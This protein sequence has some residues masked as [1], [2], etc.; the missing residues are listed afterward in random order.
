MGSGLAAIVLALLAALLT[1]I[2]MVAEQRSAAA[3]H[4]GKELV[5][6]LIRQ[7][8]WWAGVIGE[9]GGYVVQA[10]ALALGSVLLVQ[11]ILVASLL[12][13]LPLA[14]HWSGLRITG[15]TWV[16]A[17]ALAGALVVFIVVGNP[18]EGE[19]SAP[20]HRWIIPLG[21][22]L[23]VVVGSVVVAAISKLPPH[24]RA[25][26][27]GL[28]SG[29]LYGVAV[30]FTKYVVDRLEHGPI[31]LIAAWQTWAL[32]AAGMTGFYLQQKAFQVGPLSASMPSLTIAEP[33][34]AVF[35]GI[36]VLG[37]HLRTGTV[38]MVVVGCSVVVMLITTYLLSQA[39]A[40]T[41]EAA[42]S[43]QRKTPV[44]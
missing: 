7:P 38:G 43:S 4:D 34:A 10:I 30:A 31:A 24:T 20:V 5:G 17:I 39:Q 35:L 18:N 16:T 29:T 1:A 12:F 23:A 11:P 14:A 41:A 32:V 21:L 2:G 9:G 15:R 37:E 8:R 22:V 3:T 19:M 33:I 25:L 44:H 13:A 6:Q 36:A 40:G 27:F 28:A 42:Q 26:L